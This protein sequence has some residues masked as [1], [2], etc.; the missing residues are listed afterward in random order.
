MRE[1]ITYVQKL[2]DSLEPSAVTVDSSGISGPEVH[3]VREDRLT[4]ALDELPPELRSLVTDAQDLHIRW[5][6]AASYELVSPLLARLPPGF[7]LFYSPGRN[8]SVSNKLCSTLAD[9]FGEIS[10][11]TPAKSFTDLRN[12]R[13]QYFQELG[14]L[15][16]LIEY[17]KGRL[18]HP[19]DDNGCSARIEA[20][21]TAG[22]LDVSYETSQNV[23]RI[24]ALWPYQRRRVRA[25]SHPRLRT[26]VGILSTDKPKTLEAHEVGISGLL[27]VLGQDSKPSPTMFSFA[28]RHRD[29]ES[30]FSARFLAPTGLHPTLQLRLTSRSPRPLSEGEGGD[31]RSCHPYAYL[32]LPRTIFADKY[33][34]SDPLF[35]ASKNLAALRHTTQPVDLEAPEY[36]MSQWGSAILVQLAPPEPEP[37]PAPSSSSASRSRGRKSGGDGQ[38]GA[39]DEWTAEIP[40]HLR[41][42]A[43]TRGGYA[44]ISVPYPAVFW[45]CEPEQEGAVA[46]PPN[47]FEK[48]HLGYDG[49]FEEGTVFWHVQPRPPPGS[50]GDGLLVNEVRVPVLDV[51]KAG[52]VNAGT[53]AAVAVGFA[54]IVWKLIGVHLRHGYGGGV[55]REEEKVKKRQ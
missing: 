20:L 30:A 43:P 31:A 52:W 17:A 51:E 23:L 24:T 32:T 28:S 2:G 18:C 5:V 38:D 39:E 8:N 48:A 1:R 50:V 34:L 29:A 19:A 35:L 13:F 27:T 42:L 6:S 4:I 12:G 44:T 46:F 37:E 3:A 10:C 41:Y 22:S 53:A 21:S 45:A 16:H 36:A 11:S 9:I 7:H 54:W 25:A 33:Q 47:P 26:E 40:L 55:E 49:L 15:T 14:G